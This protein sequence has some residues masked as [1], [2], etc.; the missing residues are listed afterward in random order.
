MA[1][2]DAIVTV[3]DESLTSYCEGVTYGTDTRAADLRDLAEW[4]QRKEGVIFID[5]KLWLP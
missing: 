5:G 1:I 4:L 2:L 3:T